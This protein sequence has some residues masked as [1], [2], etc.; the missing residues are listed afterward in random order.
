MRTM[1]LP[2][3]GHHAFVVNLKSC[4][5]DCKWPGAL[6]K[7]DK[8][9][10]EM[11]FHDDANKVMPQLCYEL[12]NKYYIVEAVCE[13]EDKDQIRE[14]TSEMAALITGV[15]GWVTLGCDYPGGH[16]KTEFVSWLDLLM[17]GLQN[18]C[19]QIGCPLL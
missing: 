14:A 17:S 5:R 19:A 16:D 8:L 3:T 7:Y 18:M 4:W 10:S 2:D 13:N 6:A 11:C 1:A 12:W 15:R 9:L